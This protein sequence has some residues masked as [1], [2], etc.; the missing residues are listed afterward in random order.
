MVIEAV[1]S[2]AS[3]TQAIANASRSTGVDFAYLLNTAKRESSLNPQAKSNSSSA[4]GLFQFV[5]QTWLGVVKKHGPSIGLGEEAGQI[6]RNAAGRY[7]IADDAAKQAILALRHDP[8]T[9]ALAAG[10]FSSDLKEEVEAGIGRPLQDGELYLAHF[11]GASGARNLMEKVVSDPSADATVHFPKPASANKSIFYDKDGAP[12]SVREVYDRL[13]EKG[14]LGA[15]KTE[16][17]E[18][19]NAGAE[20]GI[21][22]PIG[23][24]PSHRLPTFVPTVAMHVTPQILNILSLLD[25]LQM[26]SQKEGAPF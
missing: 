22:Q 17:A 23:F 16:L 4:A 3:I 11:M 5:E 10:K 25:P 26:D 2:G 15:E 19:Y 24:T 20:P 9:S 1:T 14:R 18:S 8:T 12:R 13:V 21:S 6:T 7:V